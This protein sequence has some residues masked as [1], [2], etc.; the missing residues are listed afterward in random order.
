MA[1]VSRLD[2]G[3][4]FVNPSLR[5]TDLV[6]HAL[7]ISLRLAALAVLVAGVLG[8]GLGMAAAT[9]RWKPLD[10][11]IQVGVVLGLSV[12]SFV[13]AA[14][15]VYLLALRW[16][17]LPVAG[18]GLPENYVLPVAVL[19]IAPLA[20]IARIARSSVGQ[21]LLEDYVR[22][23]HGNCLLYTSPSPRD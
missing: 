6:A 10:N 18:W 11:A 19:S 4:S 14:V 3:T 21:T 7:P 1:G 23:A 12:P 16:P 17:L 2:F 22:T 5:V 15:L 13:S 9:A 8:I 20:I